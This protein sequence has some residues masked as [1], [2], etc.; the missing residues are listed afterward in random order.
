MTGPEKHCGKTTFLNRALALARRSL[1][2]RGRGGPA[3]F[4]IGYDGDT[5]D[6]LSNAR[7]PSVPVEPGDVV[8]S[9]ER[10]LVSSGIL[11]ELL[12][13]VPGSTPFGRLAVARARRPGSVTLV[14]PE[15]NDNV[16]RVLGFLHDEDAADT[17]FV[18]G[19]I[20]RVTQVASWPGAR[21]VYVLRAGRA[22][23]DKA[24]SRIALVARLARLQRL[25]ETERAEACFVDGPLTAETAARVPADARVVAVRDFTK[26]FLDARGLAAFDSGGR[27]RVEAAPEFG[28]FVVTLRGLSRDRFLDALPDPSLAALVA[29]NPY[30]SEAP[31]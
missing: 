21:F 22:E 6:A 27:L 10:F 24:A 26:V 5:R 11:P 3:F 17:V 7:K 31:Q 19:A 9:A 2:A 15:G 28:G 16:A 18:D 25:S 23:L 12:E 8:V 4:S 20:N 14:G 1:A 30:E 13:A 29:F